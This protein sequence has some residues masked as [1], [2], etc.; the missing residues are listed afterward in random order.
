MTEGGMGVQV[1]KNDDVI[2]RGGGGQ[3]CQNRDDVI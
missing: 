3:N 2:N 1:E